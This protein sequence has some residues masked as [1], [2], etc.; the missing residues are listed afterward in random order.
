M[1]RQ[2]GILLVHGWSGHPDDMAWL[3]QS[4]G[5][6][7]YLVSRVRLAGHASTLDAFE[8]AEWR[9]W[10]RSVE[11]AW[12][13]LAARAGRMAYVGLSTGGTLGLRMAAGRERIPA[14]LV[15]INAPVKRPVAKMA[16]ARP[17]RHFQ[18]YAPAGPRNIEDPAARAAN[19]G[20]AKLPLRAVWQ[21]D[22]LLEDTRPMLGR[23]VC[24]LMVVRSRV[25]G[26]IPAR[27]ASLIYTRTSSAV[28]RSLVVEKGW[29]VA[30][31]DHGK[32]DLLDGIL[33]F[34]ETALRP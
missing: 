34:L 25:D 20:P 30:T 23:V 14:C 21:L 17:L 12:D 13:S 8:A 28:K 27:D 1:A 15:T 2:P 3:E 6:R 22:R 29:H 11:D 5:S 31:A 7:G 24:P 10:M 18:R 26:T 16:F 4:L 32:E 33:P 9:G 19:P